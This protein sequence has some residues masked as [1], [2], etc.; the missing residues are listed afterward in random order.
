MGPSSVKP[1]PPLDPEMVLDIRDIGKV[2]D[3]GPHINIPGSEG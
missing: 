2:Q 1:V 3:Y